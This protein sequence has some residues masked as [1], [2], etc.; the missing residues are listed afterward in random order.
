MLAGIIGDQIWH[1]GAHLPNFK[2][3][4]IAVLVFLMLSVLAPLSFFAIR[5]DKAHRLA[6]REFGI[7]SSHYVDDFHRK[8]VDKGVA[9]AE[10]LLGTPDI[11]SLSDLGNAYEVIDRMRLLP[12]GRETVLRLTILLVVPLLP[13]VFTMVPFDELVKR[14]IRL[15]F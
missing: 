14:L 12:F 9:S 2:L 13:L 3:E 1:T 6:S 11:Q 5:L 8:W 10:S 7:L 15:V 4:I